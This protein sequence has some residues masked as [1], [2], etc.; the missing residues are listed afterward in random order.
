MV[1][2]ID[3]TTIAYVELAAAV[4]RLLIGKLHE[5]WKLFRIHFLEKK[6]IAQGPELPRSF[7]VMISP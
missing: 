7:L 5:T 4:L 3:H 6:N 2:D 1:R